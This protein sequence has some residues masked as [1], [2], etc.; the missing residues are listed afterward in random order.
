MKRTLAVVAVCVAS[1]SSIAQAGSWAEGLFSELKHD[2]GNVPRGADRRCGFVIKNT[3]ESPVRISNLSRTCGCTLIT[4]DE[5]IVLD[6]NIRTARENKVLQPGETARIG[7][8]LDTRTFIGNKTAE[9]TVSFDQPTAAEVRLIVSSFIRQDIVLNPGSVQIGSLSR[10]QEMTKEIDIEYAGQLN[11]QI[12]SITSPNPNLE[13]NFDEIYRKPG[14]AGYRLKVVVKPGMPAGAIRDSLIIETNDPST[15]QFPVLVAG[16]VQ[17]ELIVTPGSLSF[18][19][20]K[21][22]QTVTRQVLLRGKS[23]FQ[24]TSVDGANAGFQIEKPQGAQ[25]F[26]KV[27]VRFTGSDEPGTREVTIRVETDLADRTA[28]GFKASVQVVR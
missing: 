9:I 18:G 13:A 10:G 11:W 24:V 5:K 12:L 14:S 1:W 23:P 26:H 25:N 28:A 19:T 22:G 8:V 27:T 21:A 4:L 20:V 7:V 17:A 15:P 3:T 2:F 6:Q 16:Q